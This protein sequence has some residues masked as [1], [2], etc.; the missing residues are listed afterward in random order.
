M[1]NFT[2]HSKGEDFSILSWYNSY[3]TT[4]KNTKRYNIS[5]FKKVS[6]TLA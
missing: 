2:N 5:E 1:R 4:S 6:Q 3:S